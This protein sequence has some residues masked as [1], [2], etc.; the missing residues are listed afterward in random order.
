M[1]ANRFV[2]A[3]AAIAQGT[4]AQSMM[5]LFNRDESLFY[6]DYVLNCI[7]TLSNKN[8]PEFANRTISF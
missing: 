5:Q 3:Y 1:T 6:F 7:W 2:F 8:S 4:A